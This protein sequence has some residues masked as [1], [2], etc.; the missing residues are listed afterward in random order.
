MFTHINLQRVKYTWSS[1]ENIPCAR[2][3]RGWSGY[4]SPLEGELNMY[5]K[6]CCSVIGRTSVPYI[7]SSLIHRSRS[8]WSL[9]NPYV[10]CGIHKKLN[11]RRQVARRSVSLKM[12]L[13][14]TQ[15]HVKL[16]HWVGRV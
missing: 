14:F 9:T 16:H 15:D 7:N 11:C 3:K 13:Y 1:Q 6:L 8:D 5:K 4:T 2:Y 12:L 10:K